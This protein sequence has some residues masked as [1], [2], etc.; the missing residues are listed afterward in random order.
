VSDD[1]FEDMSG[2]VTL[3]PVAANFSM[4]ILDERDR[5]VAPGEA[6]ELGLMGPQVGL[7]YINDPERTAAS[8]TP[9]PGNASW[10]ERMYRTGD[11]V[12]LGLDGQRLDFVGRK[13]NQIKH[14]GYR[15]ELEEIEAALNQLDGVAQSAVLALA[16]RRDVKLLVAYVSCADELSEA[17]LRGGL[18]TLLP[19]YMIPQR[20]ELR[21]DLPKNANGKVD[22]LALAREH[23]AAG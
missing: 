12:R 19:P 15:I 17:Q 13:D 23:E 16:G 4:T 5:A 22:R 9:N 8:F 18:A 21:R 3:G 11:L 14:M 10:N 20:F 1:D 2:L 6:G 7:G